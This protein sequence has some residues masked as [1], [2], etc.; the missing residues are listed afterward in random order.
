MHNLTFDTIILGAGIEGLGFAYLLNKK[1]IDFAIIE[2]EKVTGGLLKS[3]YIDGFTFDCGGHFIHTQNKKLLNFINQISNNQFVKHK[4]M[5][6]IFL[7]KVYTEYPFQTNT[8]GLPERIIKEC[9]DGLIK[10]LNKEIRY[11]NFYDWVYS[12]FGDGI[13][14]RFMMPYNKKFFKYDLK[15]ITCDWV[16]RFIIRPTKE[17]FDRGAKERIISDKGYNRLYYYPETRGID[18]LIK[19]LEK[20]I[21]KA[22]IFVNSEIDSIDIN[23][24]I[25][26]LKNKKII[27]YSKLVSTIPL[28]EL[29]RLIPHKKQCAGWMN[30]LKWLSVRVLNLGFRGKDLNNAQWIYFP[31]SRFRFYRIGC[32]HN[33]SKNLVPEGCISFYIESSYRHK[34]QTIL[35]LEQTIED[36]ID[37][38]LIK[39]EYKLLVHKEIDIKYAYIIYN[40]A[41]EKT[42]TKVREYLRGKDIVLSGRYS[43]WKYSTISDALMKIIEQSGSFSQ[44]A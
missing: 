36:L 3:F 24:K 42:I 40:K 14:K 44:P 19:S 38:G 21:D 18:T 17:E 13:A 31:E 16:D 35:P 26:Y 39:K 41:R 1:N 11:D 34:P 15:K 2:K 4:R 27:K 37:I 9:R 20:N 32:Y 10:V 25:I 43:E 12:V 6:R 23:N 29:W 8:F 22:R 7:N 33:I 28:P 5:S 30:K